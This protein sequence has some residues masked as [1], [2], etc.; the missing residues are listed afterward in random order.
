MGKGKQDPDRCHD[1]LLARALKAREGVDV[2]DE[3]TDLIPFAKAGVVEE[4]PTLH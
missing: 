4:G 1:A 3:D 2:Y